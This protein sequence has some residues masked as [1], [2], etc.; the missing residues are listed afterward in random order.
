DPLL[1]RRLAA[2]E[3]APSASAAA[4]GIHGPRGPSDHSSVIGSVARLRS[5]AVQR[6]TMVSFWV[7]SGTGSEMGNAGGAA[8]PSTRGFGASRLSPAPLCRSTLNP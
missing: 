4:I 7:R 6:R 1:G 2:P 8:A 5:T 3:L